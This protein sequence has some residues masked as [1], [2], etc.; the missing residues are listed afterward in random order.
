MTFALRKFR[1]KAEYRAFS[2]MWPASGQIHCKKKKKER[3]FNSHGIG[4]EHQHR[5]R[6]IVLEHQY[7]HYGTVTSCEN[8]L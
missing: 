2:L 1:F 6:S 8:A 4:L 3:E 5:R 7:G